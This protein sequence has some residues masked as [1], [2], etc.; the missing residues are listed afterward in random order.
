MKETGI[1]FVV[2]AIIL[3]AVQWVAGECPE[4]RLDACGGG[5]ED[6]ER[7]TRKSKLE[8]GEPKLETRK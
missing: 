2:L 8:I 5:K 6:G 3:C 4:D 1:A 7:E